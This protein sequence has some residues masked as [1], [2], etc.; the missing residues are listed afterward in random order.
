VIVNGEDVQIDKPAKP[1]VF[2]D[3]FNH[4]DFDISE[5]KGILVLKLNGERARYTDI[6][7]NGDVI[8]INWKK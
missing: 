4:I 5:A 7:K 6:L 2:V 3:I 8:D 1:M